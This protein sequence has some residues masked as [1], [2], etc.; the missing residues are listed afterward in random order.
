[1]NDQVVKADFEACHALLQR[2]HGRSSF[3]EENVEHI[4]AW[5]EGAEAGDANAQVLYG[6]CYYYGHGVEED[7]ARA[8]ELFTKA[9]ENNNL[10]GQFSLAQ[11]YINEEYE[12]ESYETAIDLFRNAAEEGCTS[13]QWYLGCAYWYGNGVEENEKEGMAWY[14]RAADNGNS[15]AMQSLAACYIH[16]QCVD[17]DI[18]E[19]ER[20]MRKSAELGNEEAID[21]FKKLETFEN[22]T[23]EIVDQIVDGDSEIEW[24]ELSEF[25]SIDVA[26]AKAICKRLDIEQHGEIN[27]SGIT[28]ISLEVVEALNT[29]VSLGDE[30]HWCTPDLVLDGL[31][32]LDPDVAK[33]LSARYK[34]KLPRYMDPGSLSL[35]NL[36]SISLDAAKA[37]AAFPGDLSLNGLTELDAK[38]AKMFV[39]FKG[40]LSLDGLKELSLGTAQVLG[41]LKG[42]SLSLPGLTKADGDVADAL[43]KTKD[44]NIE[45][46]SELTEINPKLLR[47]MLTSDN[48]YQVWLPSVSTLTDETAAVIPTIDFK[49][50]CG[51][52]RDVGISLD[53]V[54]SISAKA[55]ADLATLPGDLS[56][57]GISNT[58]IEVIQALSQKK[59]GLSLE[60][61]EEI[62]DEFANA[63]SNHAGTLSLS[64]TKMSVNAA[65]SLILHTADLS[66]GYDNDGLEKL[67]AEVAEILREHPSLFSC[68][69]GEETPLPKSVAERLNEFSISEI[70]A[71]YDGSNDDG[72]ASFKVRC[73]GS[74]QQAYSYECEKSLTKFILKK[75]KLAE[76][77]ADECVELL[78]SIQA[79]IWSSI[80]RGWEIN[81]GSYGSVVIDA[82]NS[83][84]RLEHIE[85]E[86]D[87]DEDY[88]D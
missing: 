43:F 31:E 60:G 55:A 30:S 64:P 3:I 22:L 4:D 85:R 18:E 9:A 53:G 78:K 45:L 65:K 49:D 7:E 44:K 66:F 80:P 19:G 58:T 46:G 20:W 39:D 23:A 37:L 27:L 79:L 77:K 26:A 38:T 14:Q 8:I 11:I 17:V 10:H 68:K 81:S 83:T 12:N 24:H 41:A 87:Y 54:N 82:K 51:D 70:H 74:T 56:L 62:T 34:K 33:A 69:A 50:E 47:V 6:L 25:R 57:N 1:M 63:L 42:E 28:S 40:G 15:V 86:E 21:Y 5:K 73:N 59:G 71:S 61:L 29:K 35:N 2:G 16:G 36:K 48:F 32:S 76:T 84:I 13:S 75:S 88:D 72:E 52:I 67:D